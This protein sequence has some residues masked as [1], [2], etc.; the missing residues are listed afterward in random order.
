VPAPDDLLFGLPH[1]DAADALVI[2]PPFANIAWPNLAAHLLQAV[3]RAAGFEVRVL[4]ANLLWARAIG[5]GQYVSISV[6]PSE[7]LIGERVFSRAAYD[8][9]RFG[10]GDPPLGSTPVRGRSAADGAVY[11]MPASVGYT[12]DVAAL[13]ELEAKTIDWANAVAELVARSA[14]RLVGATTT[15]H[16]T[17]AS[18][19]LL[20]RVKALCPDVS[21]AIGGANCEGEM[22]EGVASL[23]AGIDYVFSGESE[24]V[25]PQVLSELS[26]EGG[27]RQDGIIRGEPIRDLDAIP[28]PDF[29]EYFD[30]RDRIGLD[31]EL[32]ARTMPEA[33]TERGTWISYETSRGCWWGEKHHCTFCGLNGEGMQF[34]AKTPKRVLAELRGLVDRHGVRSIWMVDNIMPHTYYRDLLPAMARDLPGL[35]IFYEQKAN[36]TLERI[37]A[38][39]RAGVRWIQPGIEGLA[40]EF[41]RLIDK[42]V[43]AR[44][45]LALLR[46][47]RAVGVHVFWNTL[48]G[49]PG[50]EVRTYEQT[51]DLLPLL[52]HLQPPMGN[53]R[54][55]IDRFSPYHTRPEAYGVK[56]VRPA[57][58]YALAFPPH[59]DLE[60][61]AYHFAADYESGADRRLDLID[62][63]NA[64]VR[65]WQRRWQDPEERPMLHLERMSGSHYF[66]LLDTRG[67]PDTEESLVLERAEAT[68]VLVARPWDDS[69]VIE[70]AT[71][72]R[73][74]VRVDDWYVP[75]VVA[76]PELLAEFEAERTGRARVVA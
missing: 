14:F 70:W 21:T 25:F 41:L 19:A 32:L 43:L 35:S 52:H 56:N 36:L 7:L 6:A 10:T 55:R 24:H 1:P 49:F 75:L 58:A 62:G 67:L 76:P 71:T 47:A 65:S 22:S 28:T 73:L 17:S 12:P 38:L 50:D 29:T 40:S 54:L 37:V 44:Q 13:A 20:R 27:P 45:N 9:P 53:Y 46:Y 8:L 11:E 33:R 59:A 26:A 15:F 4:Y 5:A 3:G 48:W 72:R 61:L 16:Q 69:E 64:G 2:V 30:Q 60:K 42:G 18:V 74:G 63:I 57:P 31:P 23:D 66:G 51:L 34:R 39:H 68:T